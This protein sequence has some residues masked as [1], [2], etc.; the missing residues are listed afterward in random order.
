MT[1]SSGRDV[2]AI[3][4]ARL[5]RRDFAILP[6]LSVFT[7]LFLFAASEGVARILDPAN[8]DDSCR[9]SD[10][11]IGFTNRPNCSSRLKTATGPWVINRYNECGYRTKES[12]RPQPNGSTR[13]VLLGSSV[14]EGFYVDYDNTFAARAAR[15][16]T[17]KWGR[18]VEIQNLGREQ[19]FPLCSFHR[20]DEAIALKPD[21]VILAVNPHD[22]QYATQSDVEH[23]YEPIPMP[24]KGEP[25]NPPD[26]VSRR[27]PHLPT[28][29]AITQGSRILTLVL[30]TIYRDPSA[31]LRIFLSSGGDHTYLESKFSPSWET[32]LNAFGSLVGEMAQR[33]NNKSIPFALLMIPSTPM[34]SALSVPNLP[35]GVDPYA[36]NKRMKSI[37]VNHGMEFI[38]T[39]DIFRRTPGSNAS[40][41]M[42]DG[43]LNADGNALV[44]D[45]LVEQLKDKQPE[46]HGP[47]R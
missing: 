38:D 17:Q 3:R 5:P 33:F 4:E 26:V 18:P 14:A 19:C 39:L 2:G 43:H 27:F 34:A 30:D 22:L 44:G 20:V 45:A 32:H 12:C 37:A 7:C 21:L 10:A 41:Y 28:G 46:T 24:P 9:T 8:D 42:V 11:T 36:L 1:Q 35:A 16:L 6:L 40:F 15:N 31:H 47:K 25:V 23:R 29:A 13:I